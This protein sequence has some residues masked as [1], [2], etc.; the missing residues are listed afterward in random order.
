MC[1]GFP[2]RSEGYLRPLKPGDQGP[3]LSWDE[4]AMAKADRHQL[5]DALPDEAVDR[6]GLPEARSSLEV[7]PGPAWVWSAQWQDQLRSSLADLAEGHTRSVDNG[8]AFLA[9]L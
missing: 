7:D 9:S 1:G 8:D 4:R 2:L 5:M 3:F 6:A